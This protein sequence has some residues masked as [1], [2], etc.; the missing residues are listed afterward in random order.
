M[1]GV[2][3]LC[4][5][6][7]WV[8]CYGRGMRRPE[9]DEEVIEML[10]EVINESVAVPLPA[11]ELSINQ[12]LRVA[13]TALYSEVQQYDDAALLIDKHYTDVESYKEAGFDKGE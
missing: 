10:E 3:T 8:A 11:D 4:V 7:L 12:Q 13:V 2:C 6:F 5:G 9:V 1:V